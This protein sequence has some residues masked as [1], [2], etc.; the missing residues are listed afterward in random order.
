MFIA[1]SRRCEDQHTAFG[2]KPCHLATVEDIVRQCS[3]VE[4]PAA[5]KRQH[6]GRGTCGAMRVLVLSGKYHCIISQ[7][8]PVQPPGSAA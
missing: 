5:A 7:T 2:T 4:M 3:C 8:E 6:D 1:A